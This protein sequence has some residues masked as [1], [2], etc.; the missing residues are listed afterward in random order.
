MSFRLIQPTS[1][2][3]RR[4]EF[5]REGGRLK[6]M[7]FLKRILP[8]ICV[9]A[10]T[11][12][13]L[14]S[15]SSSAQAQ[16]LYNWGYQWGDPA[17]NH[18]Y[19]GPTTVSGVPGAVVQISTSNSTSYALTLTGQVWA[20]GAGDFGELGNG[21]APSFSANPVLVQ[22]PAGVTIASLPSPM[23]FDA[24]MAI[25]T[26]GNIWGW[27]SDDQDAF[28]LNGG[29]YLY[30]KQIPLADVTLASGA[31]GHALYVS[32]G[33]LYACGDNVSGELGDGTTVSS[34]SPVKV[35]G[36]PA[37]PV[38]TLESSWENSGALLANGSFYDWGYNAADQLG[39]GTTANSD[40][41]VL[42]KLPAAVSQV[43]MGG[44][45]AG[46][47]QTVAKLSDGSIW[48]WGSDQYGQLGIGTSVPSSGPARVDVPQG[49]SFVQL[50]SGGSTTYGIDSNG[51]VWSWGENDVGE[52]GVGT[53]LSSNVPVNVGIQL[54]YVSSTA[55]N[56]AGL[57]QSEGTV[58]PN[59]GGYDLAGSDGGV[60]VFGQPGTGFYNSLPG[61]GVHVDNI[62]GL[63]PTADA[64]GYWM[65]GSDGGVY[66]F[67]DAQFHGSL[68]S[69]GVHVNDI[70]GMASDPATGGYWLV[71]SDGGV[72][73]FNAPFHGSMGG[74]PL[75]A[76]VVGMAADPA[77][78]GYWLV[79][80]D[81]GIFTFNAP[82]EG[83]MGGTPLNAPVVGMAADPATGGYWLVASDGGIFSFG[84]PFLGSTGAL[85]LSRPVVGMAA[86]A[87]GKG[88]WLVASDGGIFTFGD[89]VYAGSL[90]GS[91]VSV[92]NIVGA[93]PTA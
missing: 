16:H 20:W 72:F 75:N 44:S 12:V 80:S 7:L 18:E 78:G 45:A 21:T 23:P 57:F 65:V 61:I 26:R 92:S 91:D 56:V 81:G 48:A 59:G 62:V 35:V 43:S 86:T 53:A 66:A 24:G 54:S 83:S 9:I 42:V 51:E 64:K 85:Q 8:A 37:Q 28:C 90:P 29:N 87:D 19:S 93:V 14:P 2:N 49:V 47:G 25:D 27:G 84:A 67:G 68:D 39:N 70:V 76:P 55:A 38:T 50:S 46:N 6:P 77:T 73:S 58:N 41:P 63:V 31:G 89:A 79:A 10:F 3:N 71:G 34:V 4:C 36:L 22:F 74:T 32:N 40:T 69:I 88:Y 82:F 60:F 52:L 1:G 15:T 13:L 30:P 11:V 17:S 33:T 5:D